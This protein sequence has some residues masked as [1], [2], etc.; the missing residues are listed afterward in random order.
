MQTPIKKF[1]SS[2]T[3]P[4]PV[5]FI[6][7]IKTFFNNSITTPAIGPNPNAPIIAGTSLKSIVSHG[8]SWYYWKF[9]IPKYKCYC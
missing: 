9:N 4:D 3:N 2:P 7:T 8:K 5:P 1:A 6:N